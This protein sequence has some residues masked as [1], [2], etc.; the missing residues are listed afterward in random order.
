MRAKFA[1]DSMACGEEVFHSLNIEHIYICLRMRSLVNCKKISPVRL[2]KAQGRITS[3]LFGIIWSSPCTSL[4]VMKQE[5]VTPIG[6]T[7]EIL[8]WLGHKNFMTV[9]ISLYLQWL[10]DLRQKFIVTSW[11]Y[12]N[13]QH[14]CDS[15]FC[16]KYIWGTICAVP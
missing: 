12:Q 13:V 6:K 7:L 5:V 16:S 11:L 14:D 15:C 2:W 4:H 8:L 9:W 1:C 10:C 3:C